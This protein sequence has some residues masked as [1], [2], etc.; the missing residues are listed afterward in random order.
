MEYHSSLPTCGRDLNIKGTGLT[1]LRSSHFDLCQLYACFLQ[2]LLYILYHKQ[3]RYNLL[4]FITYAYQ[5]NL[6]IPTHKWENRGVCKHN[7]PVP[8]LAPDPTGSYTARCE[9][10]GILTNQKREFSQCVPIWDFAGNGGENKDPPRSTVRWRAYMS[11]A[12]IRNG[13]FNE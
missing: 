8:H 12:S 7:S 13:F 10:R 5:N 3:L 11:S 1:T 6:S 9:V 2:N 4:E